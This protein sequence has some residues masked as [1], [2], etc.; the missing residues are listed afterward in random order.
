MNARTSLGRSEQSI[1]SLQR[2]SLSDASG[3]CLR[4]PNTYTLQLRG[5]GLEVAYI[6]GEVDSGYGRWTMRPP[7]LDTVALR[8][9]SDTI[10]DA[11][12]QFLS[13]NLARIRPR[14]RYPDVYVPPG[15]AWP[16]S[17]PLDMYV[18]LSNGP[19]GNLATG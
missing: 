7:R 18:S 4:F 13:A 11:L 17:P 3:F 1:I 19:N 9:G 15:S 16:F 2:S 12:Y 6:G 5:E 14:F 10:E 8:P